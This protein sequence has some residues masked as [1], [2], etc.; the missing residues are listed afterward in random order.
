[1]VQ[2][3]VKLLIQPHQPLLLFIRLIQLRELRTVEKV[4]N[5]VT[6]D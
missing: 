5:F 3:T 2:V 6:A 1:M 4:E